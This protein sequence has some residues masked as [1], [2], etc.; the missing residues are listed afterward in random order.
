[1]IRT[2][3]YLTDQQRSELAILAKMRG[4][5]QSELIREAI[6]R[7]LAQSSCEKRQKAL[8]EAAGLWKDRA[9]LPDMGN[10]RREWDRQS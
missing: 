5:K 1:M 3:I 4:K 7:L 2:Q 9:D 6:D 8:A 10:I